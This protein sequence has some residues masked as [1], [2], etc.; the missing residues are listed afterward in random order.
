ML[1]PWQNQKLFPPEK[2]SQKSCPYINKIED[3][4]LDVL[5]ELI[6]QSIG[7]VKTRYES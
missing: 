3:I 5:E 4:D 1:I 6:G 7:F 2:A